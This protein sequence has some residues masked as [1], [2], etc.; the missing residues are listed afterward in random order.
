MLMQASEKILLLDICFR[1]LLERIDHPP[2][3]VLVPLLEKSICHGAEHGNVP[4]QTADK[5][6]GGCK[7][8]VE[9][10]NSLAV[11]GQRI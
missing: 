7:G 6:I 10:C 3:N 1:N 4:V 2:P 5:I 9:S 11:R 8:K